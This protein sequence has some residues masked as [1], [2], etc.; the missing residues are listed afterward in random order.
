M[1][2][3]L[4]CGRQKEVARL[5]PKTFYSSIVVPGLAF[6]TTVVPTVK[7]DARAHL[8]VQAIAGQETDWAARIQAG[9]GP[10]RSFWQFEGV[11][12]GVGELFRATPTQLRSVCDALLIPCGMLTV[13]EAMAW[14]DTLACSMAR[15][16]LW[17]DPHELP[18]VGDEEGGW[19]YYIRN[20][21]PGAPDRA[22]WTV[23]Y[24]TSLSIIKAAA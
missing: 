9:G 16:L 18:P 17:Q 13:F 6:L 8:L 14:N 19:D 12:G 1:H 21:A 10:A 22:R 23:R 15:L 20:W 7:S 3:P 24:Q 5:D 4:E 11:S 2:N